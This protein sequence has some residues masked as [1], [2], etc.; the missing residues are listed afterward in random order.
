MT[1]IVLACLLEV[2]VTASVKELRISVPV[3]KIVDV[4]LE[5]LVGVVMRYFL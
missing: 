2:A 3:R 5:L 4:R 1:A